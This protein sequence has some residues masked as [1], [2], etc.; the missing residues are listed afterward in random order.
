M[1]YM[2]LQDLA[3]V[4]Q[5]GDFDK[6]DKTFNYMIR[7]RSQ[8]GM[9][10]DYFINDEVMDYTGDKAFNHDRR[11]E[12]DLNPYNSDESQEDVK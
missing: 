9:N 8:V 3:K 1:G 5:I 10:L 4:L 6:S 2:S 11:F 12:K 7:L